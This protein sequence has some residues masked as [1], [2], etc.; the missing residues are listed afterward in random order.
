GHSLWRNK[1][2]KSWMRLGNGWREWSASARSCARKTADLR[3]T[4]RDCRYSPLQPT[5]VGET[6]S[7]NDGF[8]EKSGNPIDLSSTDSATSVHVAQ[9]TGSNAVWDLHRRLRRC[10]L[11]SQPA[12]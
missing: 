1:Q 4:F 10:P 5:V 8:G 11:S 3:T 12:T 2:F 6:N 7:L 9:V